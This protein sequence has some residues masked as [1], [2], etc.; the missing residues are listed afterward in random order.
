MDRVRLL[1]GTRNPGKARE[2]GSLLQGVPVEV[3][4]LSD[5]GIAEE[6]PE[7]GATFEENAVAKAT[8]YARLT[9]LWTLA[10]D[11]GLEVDALGGEPGVH[12]KRYAPT[13]PERI[14]RLLA[15]LE[16]VPW[17]RR[18]ARFRCVVALA[19]PGGSV[20][21][22][23]GQVRGYITPWPAG[24][25]GFGYDPV[26]Y[27]KHLGRTM[28]QLSTEEKNAVSHRGRA[29]RAIRALLETLVRHP[30]D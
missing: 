20:H 15:R 13:D 25:G 7:E 10:D 29:V 14:A 19:L 12:S 17:E 26:F 21:R 18:T 16:G 24:N 28:A 6:V 9:G 2:I 5:L 8:A 4:T 1:L 23:Y 22:A 3:V 30:D 11:S 27:L